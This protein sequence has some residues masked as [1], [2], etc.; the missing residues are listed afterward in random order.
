M[1]GLEQGV[2]DTEY[3]C[4]RPLALL[5]VD[6][7]GLLQWSTTIT[8]LLYR[9]SSGHIA[10]KMP[11]ELVILAS[12]TT[13]TTHVRTRH[14]AV[15]GAAVQQQYST[16]ATSLVT[17]SSSESLVRMIRAYLNQRAVIC[18]PGTDR[19][20]CLRRALASSPCG[21]AL[22]CFDAAAVLVQLERCSQMSGD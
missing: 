19:H 5:S 22:N 13:C 20:C 18:V 1:G 8:A 21:Q 7:R 15:E 3:E 16:Y 17:I 2:W 10:A 14:S 12:V 11:S 4:S 6:D 9:G